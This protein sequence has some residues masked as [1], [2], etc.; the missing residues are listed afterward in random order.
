MNSMNMNGMNSMLPETQRSMEQVAAALGGISWQRGSR[1][2]LGV[3]HDVSAS[4]IN[5]STSMVGIGMGN[6][7]MGNANVSRRAGGGGAAAGGTTSTASSNAVK[8]R[9]MHRREPNSLHDTLRS[10]PHL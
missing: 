1:E 9:R 5:V 2:G 3:H 6:M 4:G 8:I 7:N 10:T